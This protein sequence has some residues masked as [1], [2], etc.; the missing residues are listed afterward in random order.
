MQ[1]NQE[2]RLYVNKNITGKRG[3]IFLAL[4]IIS[5]ITGVFT[6]FIDTNNEGLQ[7]LIDLVISG[8]T[9]PLIVG[10]YKLLI[11]LINNK[12]ANIGQ[13][14]D[15]Y[16]YIYPLFFVGILAN[17]VIALA[18][19]FI[20][21]GIILSIIYTGALYIFAVHPTNDFRFLSKASEKLKNKKMQFFTLSLS[22]VWPIILI[23]FIYLVILICNLLLS[24]V[25]LPNLVG[26]TF[27]WNAAG[28]VLFSSLIIVVLSVA[29]AITL[30]TYTIIVIPKLNLAVARFMM[31]AVIPEEK[32]EDHFCPNC[33]TK[34]E[35]LYCTNCGT[36]VE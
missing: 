7:S 33:G 5:A 32:V 13:L 9:T 17:I 36:K 24:G 14:F 16:K 11:D 30:V 28:N 22:Y 31:L 25:S 21:P 19:I 26:D 18:S 27:M 1:T 2:I 4:F 23:F 3:I 29:L 12:K 34:V 6:S 35:T 20:V 10:F 15:Y 8:L